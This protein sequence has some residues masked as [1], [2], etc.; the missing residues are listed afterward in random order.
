[1]AKNSDEYDAIIIG[2]G[3]NGLVCGA[4]LA[5]AGLRVRIVEKRAILGGA[6]V[7]EEFHPGFRNS[8]YSYAVSLLNPKVIADLALHEHGLKILP[9]GV[10]GWK[11]FIPLD[12]TNHFA[13]PVD[14]DKAIELFDRHCPGDGK[15][16]IEFNR[17]LSIAAEALRS[18]VLD[19]PPNIGGDLKSIIRAAFLGNKL[20][21]LDSDSRAELIKLMTMSVA[22]YLNEFFGGEVLKGNLG[23]SATVGNMQ[24]VCAGG[25]AYVLLHHVFGEVNGVKGLWGQAI[26]GMGAITKAIAS[27][28]RRYGAEISVATGVREL[29]T[30][31]QRTAGVV[32]DDGTIVRSSVVVSNLNPRLLFTKLVNDSLLPREF[33]R[34][35]NNWRCASG[36]FRM[37]V[38]LSELPQFSSA[39]PESA[40]NYRAAAVL[41]APSLAYLDQAFDDAKRGGIANQPIIEMQIPSIQDRSL[42]PDGAH[43]ASLFCQFFAYEQA[44][45]RTWDE[46]E[47]EVADHIIDH[48]GKFAPNFKRAVVARQLK[49]PLS[50]E[51][52]LGMVHGDI[53]HGQLHL[54]QIFSMRPAPGYADYRAPVRGLYMCGSGTHPGGGVT[55]APGR[56][57]A[58][59]ILRDLKPW[60]RVAAAF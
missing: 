51:R 32:L 48:L 20:R 10:N 14:R 42:A 11:R 58:R 29:L 18:I 50:I 44:D 5:Q 9:L 36:V 6:A 43:V 45:G 55:G 54:D 31:R 57:A 56:N 4:Y 1:M 47:N 24:S 21:K 25:S 41:T 7:T 60:R 8:V 52:D 13:I 53:F 27:A 40:S 49:S 33:A 35:M 28:A 22:D 16:F 12:P 39:G 37:N 59:E 19:T 30:E 23:Y 38:A 26:G 15:A 46:K 17:R 2:G 3:H 34:R